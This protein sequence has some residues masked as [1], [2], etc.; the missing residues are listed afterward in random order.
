MRYVLLQD[1][2][3]ANALRL[4]EPVV[5]AAMYDQHRRSPVID[6]VRGVVSASG[7]RVSLILV[8]CPAD[9]AA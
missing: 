1:M 3:S 2:E 6:E 9:T 4:R 7:A 5:L 8:P